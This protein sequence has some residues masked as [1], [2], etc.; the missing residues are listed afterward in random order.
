MMHREASVLGGPW[1]RILQKT[2]WRAGECA[3]RHSQS[4]ARS[5]RARLLSMARA[6]RHCPIL[7]AYH[8][9]APPR[10]RFPRVY[11]LALSPGSLLHTL[12]GQRCGRCCSRPQSTATSRYATLLLDAAPVGLYAW[13]AMF[14]AGAAR[15]LWHAVLCCAMLPGYA[16][17][18]KQRARMPRGSHHAD[19]AVF[20]FKCC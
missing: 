19:G 4:L 17:T 15:L 9:P 1:L 7:S 5:R 11:A 2:T 8:A 16:A 14:L 10:L 12:A 20:D 3:L 6:S 13:S 18:R